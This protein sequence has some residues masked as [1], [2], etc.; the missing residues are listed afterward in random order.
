M[1]L[2]THVYVYYKTSI[3]SSH[4]WNDDGTKMIFL[5]LFQLATRFNSQN[6]YEIE[7]HNEIWHINL[8]MNIGISNWHILIVESRKWG[9]WIYF[10]SIHVCWPPN[11][12]KTS[13]HNMWNKMERCENVLLRSLNCEKRNICCNIKTKF[14]TDVF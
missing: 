8:Y 6:Q 14:V 11:I 7:I 4:I 2:L 1:F 10:S 9:Y 5:P 13:V 12:W 3:S